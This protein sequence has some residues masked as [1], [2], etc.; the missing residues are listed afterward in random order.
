MDGEKKKKKHD[1]LCH[2]NITYNSTEVSIT[3]DVLE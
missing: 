2:V 1:M 3:K